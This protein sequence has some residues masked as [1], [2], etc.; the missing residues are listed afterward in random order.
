MSLKQKMFPLSHNCWE[1]G[2]R[3]YFSAFGP[4]QWSHQGR[5]VQ[6]SQSGLRATHTARP[7]S[8]IR[9]QKSLLSSGGMQVRS[10]ISTFSGS[11]LPSVMPYRLYPGH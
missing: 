7:W 4:L 1:R 3:F 9:W 5:K 8:T 11:L 2:M 6:F 10:C